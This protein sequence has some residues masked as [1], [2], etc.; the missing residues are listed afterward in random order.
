MKTPGTGLGRR[1]SAKQIWF[2]GLLILAAGLSAQN[3]RAILIRGNEWQ[4]GVPGFGSNLLPAFLGEYQTES[5]AVGTVAAIGRDFQQAAFCVR[6][7]D[8]PAL[9]QVNSWQPRPGLD[10][11]T[12]LRE[13]DSLLI[14]FPFTGPPGMGSWTILFQFPR[15]PADSGPRIDDAE[16]NRLIHAWTSRV[17]YFFSQVKSFADISLPAVVV[18]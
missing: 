4:A 15:E 18:F 17:S 3:Q 6:I 14:A 9:V 16:A 8:N 13:K 11:A 7:S 2:F 10:S 1:I 5:A 12:H